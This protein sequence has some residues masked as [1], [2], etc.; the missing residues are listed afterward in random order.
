MRWVATLLWMVIVVI[1]INTLTRR[2]RSLE[3]RVA[4][5][6]SCE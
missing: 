3:A 2:V 1:A 4:A 6:E 5:L